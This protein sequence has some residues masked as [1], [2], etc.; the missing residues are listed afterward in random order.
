M[1]NA[2]LKEERGRDTLKICIEGR[3]AATGRKVI[4]AMF[5]V[6]AIKVAFQ[7]STER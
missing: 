6:Q 1:E 7:L 2:D 5:L 4:L 3:A